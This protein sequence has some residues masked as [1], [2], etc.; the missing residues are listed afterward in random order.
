[1]VIVIHQTQKK[2]HGKEL[3]SYSFSKIPKNDT[4]NLIKFQGENNEKISN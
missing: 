4:K 1:M 2:A 3:F